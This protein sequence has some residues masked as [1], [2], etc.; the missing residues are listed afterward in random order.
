MEGLLHGTCRLSHSAI[1]LTASI[2]VVTVDAW[3]LPAGQAP[4]SLLF[5]VIVDVFEIEGMDMAR[6]ISKGRVSP[7]RILRELAAES[8]VKKLY[9]RCMWKE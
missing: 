3:S 2:D 5:A 4:E 8:K 1:T 6:D 7:S 9:N